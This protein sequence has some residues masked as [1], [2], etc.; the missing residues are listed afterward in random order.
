MELKKKAEDLLEKQ[1]QLLNQ[2]DLPPVT[3]DNACK[4][5]EAVS[6]MQLQLLNQEDLPPVTVD[7][8]CKIIEAVSTMLLRI[9]AAGNDAG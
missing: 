4:I 2:E 9:S 8:A 5:I 7:N 1:L 3:V 6:T